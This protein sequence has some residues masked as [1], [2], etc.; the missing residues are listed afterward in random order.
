MSIDEAVWR[1][2]GRRDAGPVPAREAFD[3]PKEEVRREQ[4]RELVEPMRAGRDVVVDHTFWS[5]AARDDYTAP[6]ETHGRRWEPVRPKA[7]RATP[8]RRPAVRNGREGADRATVDAAQ[9]ARYPA[10][11]EEPDGEGERVVPQPPGRGPGAGG[12][13]LPT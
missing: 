2:P 8:E 3:R 7:D 10:R 6:V 13:A 11:F 1:R 4:R 12:G 5:R 9:L